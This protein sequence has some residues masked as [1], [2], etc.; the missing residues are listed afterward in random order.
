MIITII[1]SYPLQCCFESYTSVNMQ[2]LPQCH[3]WQRITCQSK[4]HKRHR[5]D[6]WVGKIPCS[7]KWQLTPV[8]LPGEFNGQRSLAGYFPWGCRELDTTGRLS[9]HVCVCTHTHTHTCKVLC[10]LQYKCYFFKIMNSLMV[11]TISYLFPRF[12]ISS[13]HHNSGQ[14]TCVY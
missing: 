10:K 13:P 9:T 8:F 1:Q 4:R 6:P 14:A 3:W 11:R 5:F 12:T 7:R 2:R